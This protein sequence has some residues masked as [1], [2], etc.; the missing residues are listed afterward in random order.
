MGEQ[1]AGGNKPGEIAAEVDAGT[2][3]RPDEAR[4]NEACAGHRGRAFFA[5]HGRHRGGDRG[6]GKGRGGGRQGRAMAMAMG[7]GG[8]G[9][10]G[11]AGAVEKGKL[12]CGDG[13]GALRHWWR[14]TVTV[15]LRLP[16]STRTTTLPHQLYYAFMISAF[17]TC[18]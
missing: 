1:E 9:R 12:R 6:A 10:S 18:L 2:A 13:G 5:E 7:A 3:V 8:R 15:S 11:A 16:P 17:L 4:G 14:A